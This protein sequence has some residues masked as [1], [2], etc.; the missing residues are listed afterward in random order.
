VSRLLASLRADARLQ[1]RHGFYYAG[2]FVAVLMV[3][4]LRQLPRDVLAEVFPPFFAF[5]LPIT[6]F[7]FV[8]GLLLL[9]KGEGTL[10]ALVVTPL[11]VHEYLLS[12]VATLTL[13]AGAENLLV[14]VAVYGA[15]VSW[16]PLLAGFVG[17]SA[18]YTCLGF[19][20]VVRYDSI[21]EF[22]MP[23]VL[24]M[25]ALQVPLLDYVGIVESPVFL[26][27]PSQ[28]GLFVLRDAFGELAG[29]ERA[30]AA[31]ALPVWVGLAFW[32]AR[33]AFRRLVVRREGVHGR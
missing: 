17:L 22:L 4:G 28:A 23:S 24:F 1:F 7:Y 8:A 30:Y 21:N 12:K 19:V 20:A 13:L 29:W 31:L 25:M 26:A 15:Q 33:R 3:F 18:F 11:R 27:W 32:W 9:E 10:E 5:G 6:T 16:I 2:G 14:L